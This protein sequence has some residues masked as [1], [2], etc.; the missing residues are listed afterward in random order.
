V[1]FWDASAVVPLLAPEAQSAEC[2]RS[3]ET[4]PVVIVWALTPVEALSA[5]HRKLRDKTM[6]EAAVER[7]RQRLESL[8]GAWSEVN[9]L[10]LVRRRAERLLATHP[11]RAADALQL[12]AALVVCD[13]DPRKMPFM[14]LDENLNAAARREG[15]EVFPECCHP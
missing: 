14:S 8:R 15:F 12:A 6:N 5:L 7:A 1:K 2:T 3:L 10:E 11:L 9:D 13:E 4:D